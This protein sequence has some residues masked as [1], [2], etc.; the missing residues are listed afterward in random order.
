MQNNG[1]SKIEAPQRATG[2]RPGGHKLREAFKIIGISE[3][4]GHALIDAGKI[5]I[6]RMGPRL[7]IITDQEIDRILAEGLYPA[8]KAKNSPKAKRR[9]ATKAA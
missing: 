7:P 1:Q 3:G 4:T 6:V 9:A 2:G 5:K 8:G